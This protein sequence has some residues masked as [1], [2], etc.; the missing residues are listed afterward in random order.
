MRFQYPLLPGVLIKR[1][2]RFLADIQ[3]DDGAVITA[4]CANSGSLRRLKNPGSRVWVMPAPPDTT[5]KL[6]YDW[7]LIEDEGH[8]VG[9]NTSWPNQLVAEALA[10][11]RVTELATY[12]H[13]RREVTWGKSRF[14]FML[15]HDQE[16]TCYL[17]VKSVT[18][19]EGDVAMFPDA[20]TERGAKHLGDLIKLVQEG[21]RACLLYLVQRQDCRAFTP[22]A[23]IDPAYAAMAQ[24]ARDQGVTFLCYTSRMTLEGIEL[25][26]PLPIL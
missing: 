15:W 14:D 10:Q 22:A 17:E 16:P 21:H 23:S 1:Y 24:Q 8:L 6:R 9:I 3:L 5:R 20:V 2:K 12:T 4:H 13:W 18:H 19:K 26:H 25:D 11:Q 7:H